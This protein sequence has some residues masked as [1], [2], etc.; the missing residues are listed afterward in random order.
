[1]LNLVITHSPHLAAM[2]ANRPFGGDLAKDPSLLHRLAWKRRSRLP[3][4]KVVH[5][6]AEAALRERHA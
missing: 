1:M 6:S 5:P 3:E 2:A 4:N